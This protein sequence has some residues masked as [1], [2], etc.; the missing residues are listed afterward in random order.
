M[1]TYGGTLLYECE[2]PGCERVVPGGRA[3]C[4]GP[5]RGSLETAGHSA[6]CEEI[7][8]ARE[9]FGAEVAP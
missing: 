1:A 5:C 8:Q 9:P 2:R 6:D 7:W 3:F 4:C